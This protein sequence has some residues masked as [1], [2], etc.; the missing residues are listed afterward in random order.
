MEPLIAVLTVV[1]VMDSAVVVFMAVVVYNQARWL[2][3]RRFLRDK[4]VKVTSQ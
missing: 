1:F 2:V 3:D 4:F